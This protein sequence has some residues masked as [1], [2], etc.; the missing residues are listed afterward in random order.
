M[1]DSMD[2]CLV[3]TLAVTGLAFLVIVVVQATSGWKMD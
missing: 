3:I 2:K 1:L